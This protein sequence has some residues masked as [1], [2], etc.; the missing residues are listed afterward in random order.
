MNLQGVLTVTGEISG[1]GSLNLQGELLDAT[2]DQGI[3]VRGQ[4]GSTLDAVTLDGNMVVAGGGFVST[5]SVIVLDGLTLG[6]AITLGGANL[7]GGL[8]FAGTQTLSGDGSVSL[9]AT[10]SGESLIKAIAWPT[11]SGS[12]LTIGQNIVIGGQTAFFLGDIIDQGTIGFDGS[13]LGFEVQT[14][15]VA[16]SGSFS[17]TNGASATFVDDLDNAGTVSLSTTSNLYVGGSYTQSATGTLQLQIGSA[18]SANQFPRV[19]VSYTGTLAGTLQATY[20]NGFTPSAGQSY[21]VSANQRL[22]GAFDNVFGGQVAYV[23]TQV[24]L[25]ISSAQ[26]RP[27]L[28]FDPQGNGVDVG[29]IVDGALL[30]ETTTVDLY[31]ASGSAFADVIGEAIPGAS[32]EVAEGS[33][34]GTYG[35]F[36]IHATTLGS[37]PTGATYLLAVADPK[38]LLGNF[39]EEE[40][41]KALRLL[42]LPGV[43]VANASTT[44]SK[45][46]TVNYTVTGNDN[47]TPFDLRVYRSNQA[48][49]DP[50][51]DQ[52]VLVAQVPIQGSDAADGTH[53]IVI[54]PAGQNAFSVTRSL[55]PDP[56]HEY[57]IATADDDGSLNPG[58][59]NNTPQEEFRILLVADVTHGLT[60]NGIGNKLSMALF[61]NAITSPTQVWVDTMAGNLAN[62]N[63]DAAFGFHWEQISNK[64]LPAPGILP[65]GVGG[66]LAEI[67]GYE[68][69]KQLITEV[70]SSTPINVPASLSTYTTSTNV[71]GTRDP[72]WEQPGPNDVVDVQFIGHSRGSVVISQALMDL[73]DTNPDTTFDIA[74]VP[75]SLSAGFDMMTMLDPHPANPIYGALSAAGLGGGVAPGTSI[76]TS[77]A[78]RAGSL[79]AA[80]AVESFQVSADDKNVV[81]PSNVQA[82]E[83]YYQQS[84]TA[85]F[86]SGDESYVNLW[87]E[88]PAPDQ[89]KNDSGLPL[90]PNVNVRNVSGPGVGHMEIHHYYD[91]QVVEFQGA[92]NAPNDFPAT[93]TK[94]G[95]KQFGSASQ[96]TPA[97]SLSS[98]SLLSTP[99]AAPQLMAVKP[100]GNVVAGAPFG[101]DIYALDPDGNVDSTFNGSVTLGLGNGPSGSALGGTLV[102][103]AVNGVAEFSGLTLN[104]PG[105][106]YTLQATANGLTSGVTLP[107][108]VT[109]D[110]L[111]VTSQPP[112]NVTAGSGFGLVVSA[113]NAAGSVDTSFNG[114]VAVAVSLASTNSI[115]V[116]TMIVT[117]VDGVA[118]FSGL[119][120]GGPG[121]YELALTTNGVGSATANFFQ[122]NAGTATQ[123]VVTAEPPNAVSTGAGFSLSVAAE[124][125]YGNVDPTY[126]GPL[127][128]SLAADPSGAMLGGTTTT[129]AVNGLA[130]FSG[131]TIGSPANGYTI[132]AASTGL[133]A[134]TTNAFDTAPLGQATQLVVT[135]QP[136]GSV[137][138]GSGFG[139]AVTAEDSFGTVDANFNGSVTAENPNGGNPLA[140]VTAVNGVATFSGLTLDQASPIYSLS[141]TSSGL[142]AAS[143][144]PFEVTSEPATKLVPLDPLQVNPGAEFDFQVVAED[145]LGNV[146]PTFD[147]PVTVALGSNPRGG[148]LGGTL[149]VMAVNG[150]ADF[151]DLTINNAG[152]GYTIQA[153]STGLTSG[154]TD[155]FFVSEDQFVVTTQSPS[156]VTIG[157]SF[158]LTVTAEDLAGNTDSAFSGAVTLNLLNFGANAAVLGGALTA[159]AVNGVAAFSGLTIDQLG[160]YAVFAESSGLGAAATNS[161]S[162]IAS[163]VSSVAP[164]PATEASTTFDVNWSGSDVGGPGIASYDVYVS[165]DGGRFTLW[166]TDTTATS[167]QFGGLNAHTY[168]F[169]SVA[170]DNVGNQQAV[171]SAAQATT[172]IVATPPGNVYVASSFYDQTTGVITA[173]PIV[174]DTVNWL[175]S[176][177]YAEID[178]LTFG[179]TAFTSVQTAVDAV[180]F[181][182]TVDVAAGTYSETVSI[183]QPLTL[184]GAENGAVTTLRDPTTGADTGITVNTASGTV[185]IQGCTVTGFMTG[186]SVTAGTVELNDDT[187]S[188]NNNPNGDGGGIYNNG[189]LMVAGSTVSGNS[190]GI[191]GGIYNNGTLTASRST[192]SG[193]ST[194]VVSGGSGGGIYNHATLTLTDSTICDNFASTLGIGG[195]IDNGG[196]TLKIEQSTIS[197]NSAFSGGGIVNFA[198]LTLADSTLSGNAATV[199]AGLENDMGTV[200]VT[201]SSISRNAASGSFAHGGGILNAGT[202]T[203]T[204]ST[205]SGNAANA[206]YGTGGG[207]Y[208]LEGSAT[209]TNSTISG[210]SANG[211][212][213]S[214]GGVFNASTLTLTDSTL[215]GNAAD[216]QGGGIYNLEGA[217]TLASSTVSG[218]LAGSESNAGVG[219]GIY[220]VSAYGGQ[221]NVANSVLAG[222]TVL[223]AAGS[224][225]DVSGP[226]G[227]TDQDLIGVV[228]DAT[229]FTSAG[230]AI[231]GN[232]VGRS[233]APVDPLLAPLGDYGGPTQTMALL[234]GSPAIDAGDNNPPSTFP[235]TPSTDQR[236]FARTVN[237][238]IDIGAFE[239]SGFTLVK[240][241]GTN[242]DNQSADIGAAFAS[243][244]VVAV[245]ANNANEPVDG[246]QITF[247]G[248][249]SGASIDPNPVTTVVSGGVAQAVPTANETV[250]GPYSV[251]ASAAGGKD[252]VLF[253][254]T[255]VEP[256]TIVSLGPIATDPRNVYMASDDVTFSEPIDLT[257]FNYGALS[258]TLNGSANLI[259]SGVTIS[260]VSGTTDTYRIAG[261]AS[262]TTT[263]GTYVLSVDASKVQDSNGNYGTGTANVTWLMDTTPPT[264]KVNPLPATETSYSFTVSVT[265]SDPPPAS[266][267]GIATS[268]VASYAIY[269]AI[270]NGAFALWTTLPANNPSATY[271][272]EAQHHYYFRSVATDAAGNIESKQVLIEAGT[273]VPDLTPPVTK[274]ASESFNTTTDLF[275]LNL[276]GSDAGGS[277]L[278][279]FD[280]FVQVYTGGIGSTVQQIATAAAGSPDAN[281]NYYGVATYQVPSN[282]LDGNQHTYRFYSTGIDGAGNIEVAHASPNDVESTQTLSPPPSL[283]VSSLVIEKGLVERSFIRYIDIGFN[284]SGAALQSLID[285]NDIRLI[286]HP[287]SGVISPSDPTVPLAGLLK[288]IDDANGIA[289]IIEIDFGALALGGAADTPGLA[290][291]TYWSELAAGDGYYE[292]D[293]D[294]GGSNPANWSTAAHEFFY[295]LLGDV[296]GDHIV[297]G[298]DLTAITAALGQTGPYINADVNGDGTVNTIDKL[299][300]LKSQ[301]RALNA[302]LE[303]DG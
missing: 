167:A 297:N 61:N 254:L 8:V 168:S 195:G 82:V 176:G 121:F 286:Q 279:T 91:S 45:N 210:N 222:N 80:A 62:D 278:A 242:G 203:V 134:A 129:M 271:Y 116:G 53:E 146:D 163:P 188:G 234:P 139:L 83:E 32:Q 46:L 21:W 166:Q 299:L 128:L 228:G 131:L 274:V 48:T 41:V 289:D 1:S 264:S 231:N 227:T 38:N 259:N 194:A 14:L 244:L 153:G 127:T 268:G 174:G 126:N 94:L 86:T 130:S 186:V 13:S 190:A 172:T 57:V 238:T 10:L 189:T 250:G 302:G 59:A 101:L 285:N 84:P 296:N 136:A 103:S 202:L 290:F 98:L 47:Q 245:Y 132:E 280:V 178:N 216:Y 303:L 92:P 138:A 156:V 145:P 144:N 276:S 35:P 207:I 67:A 58:D 205:I 184:Q 27:T 30:P 33:P 39:S 221:V 54:G 206:S 95:L 23:A 294:T 266:E 119:T 99:G 5:D 247:A 292:L 193:N 232:I 149:T 233:A 77:L 236:G 197:G 165:D 55:A 12:T 88:S 253:A 246:G 261:L 133:T 96:S 212:Y 270:D 185:D 287:L 7:W 154:S 123:L 147:G 204:N 229:G 142:L 79:V 22:V 300:A 143:T 78:K 109:D 137:A 251:T 161:F 105:V 237:G 182:G 162:V 265:G 70:K 275:T 140:V 298:A 214:G 107:F 68:M 277:G 65:L 263:D 6:G 177:Q 196:G 90:T 44:D 223:G 11:R 26:V 125:A 272:G 249:E 4:D 183:R 19:D 102:A 187:I 283:A 200:T 226:F 100:S 25:N 164:L 288:V 262:V 252:T 71:D 9:A 15:S 110:Q 60:L 3:S 104:K 112:S 73:S 267:P 152:N 171:P 191:G 66:D 24:Y 29:Y 16:P 218:N 124:D 56:T 201:N 36:H 284:E 89:I 239:S 64:T 34:V 155:P 106:A 111:V 224:N 282:L 97:L 258:L 170:T 75:R 235:S 114:R 211:S 181:G 40:N 291:S 158:G 157:Q 198:T 256:L 122:V 118:T 173:A 217:A 141:V 74:N 248:P 37:R 135:T 51:N 159:N 87:G 295:R 175:A 117:A 151:P 113:E 179:A 76:L 148:T 20:V 108:D 31:W 85:Y 69:A 220:S 225:P 17:L 93:L 18:P 169:Y 301:N 50:N 273:Y 81:I 213:A 52:Q 150:V 257:N 49:Y 72:N 215:A 269:V 115:L 199:G 219:G 260:L 2:I 192:V 230:A 240:G 160:T 180:A 293:I 43:F 281:G 255:N 241:M 209:L 63:Y 208:N 243:P 42:Q 120:L 28:S